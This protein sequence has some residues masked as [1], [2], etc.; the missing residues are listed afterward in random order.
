MPAGKPAGGSRPYKGPTLKPLKAVRL[1][2]TVKGLCNI[3]G[4]PGRVRMTAFIELRMWDDMP[5][6]AFPVSFFTM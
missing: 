1:G 3:K 2:P 6:T 5:S 4:H